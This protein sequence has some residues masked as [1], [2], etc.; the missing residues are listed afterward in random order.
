MFASLL[1]RLSRPSRPPSFADLSESPDPRLLPRL[2]RPDTPDE[3]LSDL[4]RRWRND[5][6]VILPRFLPDDLI[7]DYV[8]VRKPIPPCGW[9]EPTPY[10]HVSEMRALALYPP[11]MR[12]LAHLIGEEMVLHLCLTGW[13][14]TERTWHQDDYLND[15][16]VNAWYTAVW[17]ALDDIHPDAGPFQWIEG[18]HRWP[19]M[20]GAKVRRYLSKAELSPETFADWPRLAER[21]VTTAV[22]A[23]IARRGGEVRS[24]IARKGDVLIWHGRLMHRGSPPNEPGRE[25]RSL[26]AHYSGVTHRQDMPNRKTEHGGAYCVVTGGQKA[27]M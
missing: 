17:M 26:I 15:D 27:M 6:V 19:L 21:F 14:S 1:K 18:S 16:F 20:R 4:Q 9:L 23:E 12:T 5:G 2:D 24:F 11:L 25:R 22:D 10:E 13:V 7:A 8:A 3:G